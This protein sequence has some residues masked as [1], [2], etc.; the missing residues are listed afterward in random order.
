ML[1]INFTKY[2]FKQLFNEEMV[3]FHLG[4]TW[5]ISWTQSK[6]YIPTEA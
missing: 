5:D 1:K 3:N 6:S 2:F 4:N